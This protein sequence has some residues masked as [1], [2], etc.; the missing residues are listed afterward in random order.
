M[1]K[2]DK[3]NSIIRKYLKK[4]PDI[5]FGY[6]GAYDMCYYYWN[7]EEECVICI[8]PGDEA[9]DAYIDLGIVADYCNVSKDSLIESILNDDF[10]K[11]IIKEPYYNDNLGMTVQ[12]PIQTE[13]IPPH[14]IAKMRKIADL[15]QVTQALSRTVDGWFELAGYNIEEMRSGDG[16]SLEELDYGNDV[17]KEF[18]QWF[19]QQST[20]KVVGMHLVPC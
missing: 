16:I 11:F 5:A 4:N 14:I 1:K 15:N 17:S 2:E 18:V 13:D 12:K 10:S 9:Y 3:A 7:L 8:F 6:E 20:T 19:S